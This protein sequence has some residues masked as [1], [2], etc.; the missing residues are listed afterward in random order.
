MADRVRRFGVKRRGRKWV[1]RP[2]IARLGDHKWVG[3]FDTEEEALEAARKEIEASRRL[4]SSQETVEGFADRWL[5]DYARPKASTND[6]HGR[7]AKKFVEEHGSKKLRDVTRLDARRFVNEHRASAMAVRAMF[8]DALDEGIIESNPF[9]GLKA[10]NMGGEQGRKNLVVLSQQ[11]LAQLADTARE[12]HPEYP[13]WQFLVFAA[14]TGM[15]PSEIYAL[16]WP[17]IDFERSEIT[18]ERQLYKRRCTTPKN[19]KTR[20]IILP[21]PAAEALRTLS[22]KTRVRLADIDGEER[23]FDLVFRNKSGGPLSQTAVHHY[24]ST[25]RTAFGRP[26]MAVYELRHFCAT[27]LLEKFRSGG[28]EGSYDV[29][30]QL[31]H[32]DEGELVRRLYGHPDGDLSRARL[33]RLFEKPTPLRGVKVSGAISEQAGR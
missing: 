30:T 27:Y 3:T 32:T 31:G 21:P 6:D 18:V 16:E 23:F 19:G 5:T 11:E 33:K 9:A 12:V 4:G 15:R 25:V 2:Y 10:L 8:S 13:F 17:D 28:E 22:R 7:K 1:A 14:Y 24:W 29:A 26:T 20:I